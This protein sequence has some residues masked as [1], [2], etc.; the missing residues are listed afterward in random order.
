MYYL[1]Y[2]FRS[3]VENR[4]R[5]IKS[6]SVEG[7]NNFIFCK[8][9]IVCNKMKFSCSV[10]LIFIYLPYCLDLK[11]SCMPSYLVF[12]TGNIKKFLPT[13][14]FSNSLDYSSNSSFQNLSDAGVRP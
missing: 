10:H 6:N 9:L 14:D 5:I 3:I 12:T 8:C 4:V 1:I 11:I 7:I 13:P 2:Q